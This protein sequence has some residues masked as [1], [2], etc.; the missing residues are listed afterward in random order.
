MHVT[1]IETDLA[2]GDLRGLEDAFRALV[3]YPQI[4]SVWDH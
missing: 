4:S 2:R 1:D 3:G